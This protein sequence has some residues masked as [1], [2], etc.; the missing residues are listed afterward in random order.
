MVSGSE[1]T[2]RD[3]CVI[4]PAKWVTLRVDGTRDGNGWES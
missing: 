4:V 2:G 3:T 1:H